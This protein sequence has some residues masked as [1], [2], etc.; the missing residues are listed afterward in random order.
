[1]NKKADPNTSA[2]PSPTTSHMDRYAQHRRRLLKSLAAGGAAVTVKALPEKWAK[3]VL[4]TTHLPAH[5]VTTLPADFALSCEV[6]N[7]DSDVPFSITFTDPL[8]GNGASGTVYLTDP[9]DPQGPWP[10]NV[11]NIHAWTDPIQVPISL[12][13][14]TQSNA[15]VDTSGILPNGGPHFPAGT[16]TLDFGDLSVTLQSEDE[17]AADQGTVDF[18]F[19]AGGQSC[20]IS[21]VFSEYP[22]A[23]GP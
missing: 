9:A 5:A 11:D 23:P 10:F 19:S 2:D 8:R 15:T 16:D 22:P 3:P 20:Q 14:G 1:M 4:D 21:V 17:N 12:V 13:I 6:G 18:T 7:V